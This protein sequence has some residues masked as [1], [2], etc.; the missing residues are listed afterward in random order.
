MLENELEAHF[1]LTKLLIASGYI[2]PTTEVLEDAFKQEDDVFNKGGGVIV[3]RLYI[4][5]QVVKDEADMN[6]DGLSSD[7]D[8]VHVKYKVLVRQGKTT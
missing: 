6:M 4:T 7:E 2:D 5:R 3:G 1:Q 8:K